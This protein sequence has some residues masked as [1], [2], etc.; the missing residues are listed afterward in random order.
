MAKFKAEC[1]EIYFEHKGARANPRV[2]FVHGLGCQL[3][4]WPD[5]LIDGIVDAGFCAVMCDNRDIGLSDGPPGPAPSVEALLAARDDPSALTPAYTLSDMADDVVALLDHLGQGGAH[6]VGLSMGGMISQRLAIEHPERVYSLTSIMSSTGNPDLP[7]PPD[8]VVGALIGTVSATDPE[9]VI[10]QSI[11]A[12]K[13]FGGPHYDSEVH[14]IG[15]F[16]RVAVERAHRPE[17]VMRQLGAILAAEDR[18]AALAELD[19]PTLVIHGNADPLVPVEAGRDTAAAVPGAKY[20]E[21]DKLGHDLS[22][23]VIGEIVE[24]ITTH[25]RDVEVSR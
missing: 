15:R 17:G 24:A 20:I 14:G 3:V 22:E 23:P 9:T 19:V 4:Q 2:L 1:G 5:S 6:V 21:I 25:L 12:A 8:E 16:A 11:Q 10:A 13:V 7:G 18:R